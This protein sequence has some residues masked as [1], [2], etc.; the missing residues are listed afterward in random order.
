M[1]GSKAGYSFSLARS[2][3]PFLAFALRYVPLSACL[4]LSL[5]LSSREPSLLSTLLRSCQS[6]RSKAKGPAVYCSL[7]RSFSVVAAEP[8]FQVTGKVQF[9]VICSL[10]LSH[11]LC[12]LVRCESGL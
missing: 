4:S 8:V 11:V 5:S 7:C 12:L 1:R 2:V 3:F 10:C 9:S 6:C